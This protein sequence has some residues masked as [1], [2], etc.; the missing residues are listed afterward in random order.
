MREWFFKPKTTIVKYGLRME[1]DP[2]EWLQVELLMRGELEAPICD[3]ME[4]TLRPGDVFVDVGSH[5]GFYS[6]VAGHFVGKTGR[7]IAIDPQPYN[8][9][10]LLRNGEL[11]GFTNLEVHIAAAGDN[12]GFLSL[13]NQSDNDKARLSLGGEHVNDT[14]QRFVVPLRRLESILQ[15][16][17]KS[18]VS[19]MKISV[20]GFEREVARGLGD[21]LGKI[22][23]LLIDIREDT[24]SGRA[25]DLVQML[26]Q[27]N[28][29]LTTVTGASWQPE[30][31]LPAN[32]LFATLSQKKVL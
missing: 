21:Q 29:A 12:E 1:L 13:P 31:T 18:P 19:F 15:D 23:H 30:Q 4:R 16:H 8:A 17:H 2:M 10:R 14:A 9:N 32:C 26:R 24:T 7:V 11:N 27:A 3:L 25:F 5:I 22:R 20:V 6:L 28:Y